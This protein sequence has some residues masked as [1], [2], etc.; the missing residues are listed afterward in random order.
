[1]YSFYYFLHLSSVLFLN[2]KSFLSQPRR[3]TPLGLTDP[4]NVCAL[5]IVSIERIRGSSASSLVW[6]T[7]Q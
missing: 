4:V 5:G 7:L 2:F 3:R 6:W 1:M